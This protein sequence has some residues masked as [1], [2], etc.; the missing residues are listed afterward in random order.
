MNAMKKVAL[1][2]NFNDILL[3]RVSVARDRAEGRREL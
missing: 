1:L 3:S 2:F